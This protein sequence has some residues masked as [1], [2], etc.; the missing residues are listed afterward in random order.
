MSL[1][2]L[3]C[4]ELN[5][6]KNKDWGKQLLAS[7]KSEK[8]TRKMFVGYYKPYIDWTLTDLQNYYRTLSLISRMKKVNQKWKKTLSQS[9]ESHPIPFLQ[10]YD[11]NKKKNNNNYYY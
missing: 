9:Q 2:V 4:C 5:T 10:E 3:L 11:N 8:A 7:F 1:D 6:L